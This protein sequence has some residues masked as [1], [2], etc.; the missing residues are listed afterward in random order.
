MMRKCA[1]MALLLMVSPSAHAAES[2]AHLGVIL[3]D[4]A[5]PQA[6]EEALNLLKQANTQVLGI[7]CSDLTCQSP[8]LEAVQLDAILQSLARLW[9]QTKY[10]KSVEQVM[11]RWDFCQ[12]NYMNEPHNIWKQTSA[13]KVMREGVIRG[14]GWQGFDVWGFSEKD[15]KQRIVPEL[16]TQN[17]LSSR[18]KQQLFYRVERQHCFPNPWSG[19]TTYDPETLPYDTFYRHMP[20]ESKVLAQEVVLPEPIKPVVEKKPVDQPKAKP[21]K[22]KV[23][24]PKVSSQPLRPKGGNKPLEHQADLAPVFHG[25]Q[26]KWVGIADGNSWTQP[27]DMGRVIAPKELKLVSLP[28]ER[29]VKPSPSFRLSSSG[30][31]ME[32]QLP[33]EPVTSSGGLHLVQSLERDRTLDTVDVIASDDEHFY[34]RDDMGAVDM[35]MSRSLIRGRDDLLLPD[36]P[37]LT[38]AGDVK[39]HWK[40]RDDSYALSAGGQWSPY[41]FFYLR[42]GLSVPLSGATRIPTYTWGFGYNDWRLGGLSLGFN[43]WVPQNIKQI[44]SWKNMEFSGGYNLDLA[45]FLPLS[46]RYQSNLAFSLFQNSPVL[47]NNW[48]YNI[49]DGWFARVGVGRQ[50]SLKQRNDWTWTYGFGRSSWKTGSFNV[51]YANWGLNRAFQPN[52]RQNGEVLMSWRWKLP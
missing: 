24:K 16:L 46:N 5:Q 11:L 37:D 1:W 48:Q 39:L 38:L 23:S 31:K 49:G 45:K 52:Y 32:S 50:L 51:E 25:A 47:H 2:L 42:G 17:H 8:R 33:S 7:P 3:R 34:S 35:P 4:E 40:L 41:K 15:P 26:G 30:L 22:K 44:P 21:V 18:A 43:Q 20:K 13:S 19:K 29:A 12:V 6:I 14:A 10:R 28:Q 27:M 36:T 9:Q